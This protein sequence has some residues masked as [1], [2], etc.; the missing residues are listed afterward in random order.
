[1]SG[2]LDYLHEIELAAGLGPSVTMGETK[3]RADTG[4]NGAD[5]DARIMDHFVRG[6]IEHPDET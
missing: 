5:G 4:K 3:R 1:M 6:L 2:L